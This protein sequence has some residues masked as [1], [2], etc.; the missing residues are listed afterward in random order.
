MVLESSIK[1]EDIEEMVQ[2]KKRGKTVAPAVED[3]NVRH[4]V[5]SSQR[6]RRS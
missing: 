5:H 3:S 6:Y 4:L 1:K 2:N